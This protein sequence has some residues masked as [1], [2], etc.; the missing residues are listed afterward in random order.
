MRKLL[1]HTFGGP[2]YTPPATIYTGLGTSLSGE[3]LT[4]WSDTGYSRQ[5]TA[6]DA[7]ASGSIINADAETYNASVTVGGVGTLTHFAIFDDV[8]AGNLL[9]VGPLSTSRS[10]VELDSVTLADGTLSISFQ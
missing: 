1:D 10:V 3:T 7:A 8:S 4:E 6:F 5:A 9:A 2:S